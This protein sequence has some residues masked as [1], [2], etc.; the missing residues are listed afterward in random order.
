[1]GKTAMP[2]G[3][4]RSWQ[5][6]DVIKAFDGSIL[7]SG[8]I[9]L[10]TSTILNEIGKDC[11]SKANSMRHKKVPIDGE[12]FL[13][14][15]INEFEKDSKGNHPFNPEN[16]KQYEG[17]YNAAHYSFRNEFSKRY[18]AD[19]IKLSED[20]HNARLQANEDA[21]GVNVGDL[22]K[23]VLTSE[24]KKAI[25]IS[26]TRAFKYNEVLFTADDAKKLQSI[27]TRTYDQLKLGVNFPEGSE[28]KK[29]YDNALKVA[30]E[31]PKNYER[32]GVK[33][34]QKNDALDQVN[35]IFKDNWGVR[36][37][38]K[39]LLDE[40]YG[41]YVRKFSKQIANDE[42]ADQEATFGVKLD[43]DAETFYKTLFKKAKKDKEKQFDINL[44]KYISKEFVIL[45]KDGENLKGY[46]YLKKNNALMFIV[47]RQDYKITDV[48]DVNDETYRHAVMTS[49]QLNPDEVIDDVNDKI[50]DLYSDEKSIKNQIIEKLNPSDYPFKELIYLR[51]E[52][53]YSKQLDG[54][55]NIDMLPVIYN[56]EKM[57]NN[58]PEG[59]FKT[60]KEVIQVTNKDY[61][62]AR[63]YAAYSGEEKRINFSNK[64]ANAFQIW[65]D[66]S[67]HQE[68]N[69]TLA[70]EVGHAVSKKFGRKGNIDYK[71][72][73]V[74]CG[75]SYQQFELKEDVHATGEDAK[76]K[77]L[78]R[79][80]SFKLLTDYA[81]TSPEEAFAEYYSIYVNNKQAIDSYIAT[82][83]ND[84]LN[85]KSKLVVSERKEGDLTPLNQ[86][87][88][89]TDTQTY[90]AVKKYASSNVALNLDDHVVL[91]LINP[92]HVSYGAST[93]LSVDAKRN[94]MS[95]AREKIIQ[96]IVVIKNKLHA[97]RIL[98]NAYINEGAKIVH[99]FVPAIVIT[100]EAYHSLS[101][102]FTPAEIINYS[103]Y[104]LKDKKIPIQDSVPKF[105]KGLEYRNDIL[106]TKDIVENIDRLKLMKHI[107]ESQSLQKA[108]SELFSFQKIRSIFAKPTIIIN[109]VGEETDIVKAKVNSLTTELEQCEQELIT[110]K[111]TIDI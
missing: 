63:G 28:E 45:D 16:F 10:Q 21:G 53:L 106:E 5:G 31:L 34:K 32:I 33:K 48:N 68:F 98:D 109:E 76:I 54:D 87:S 60:N 71:K 58:L 4:I 23:D 2:I 39:E 41:E 81:H 91:E 9:P 70:H 14:R 97:Y 11:D 104:K 66:L 64:A 47:L 36:E 42:A 17:F 77:R 55:W 18:M 43:D 44:K 95:I 59:H 74:S 50:R 27:V 82:H 93:T 108:L 96:P 13:D 57:M 99:K 80:S 56:I 72:F 101:K 105:K 40:K 26:V 111:K 79:Y 1:M 37:S 89:I 75:W 88:K 85:Q 90:D 67:G 52:T 73:V 15:E 38:V 19:K 30:D 92:W 6:G 7:S 29:I 86:L 103:T 49:W 25:R 69:S 83:N 20:I 12:L 107:F 8:W 110:I 65:G 102:K 100:E 61:N 24:Q 84:F 22:K 78:G 62:G 46:L 3:T 94:G 51:F 35:E